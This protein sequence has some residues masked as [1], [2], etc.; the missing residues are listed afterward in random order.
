[1]VVPLLCYLRAFKNKK[2]STSR[3]CSGRKPGEASNV[4][5]ALVWNI[6]RLCRRSSKQKWQ[7]TRLAT[8]RGCMACAKQFQ[9]AALYKMVWT[10]N[11]ICSCF[12]IA[13]DFRIPRSQLAPC[14]GELCGSEYTAADT[15]MWIAWCLAHVHCLH[16]SFM[17]AS[18]R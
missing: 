5:K 3:G 17:Y 14:L 10:L 15:W 4:F 1:M 13:F 6:L 8:R 18:L 16:A 12:A 7:F 11:A 9:R 2:T